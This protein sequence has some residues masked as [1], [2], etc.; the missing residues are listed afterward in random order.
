VLLWSLLVFFPVL[1]CPFG[2]DPIIALEQVWVDCVC[3]L[4]ARLIVMEKQGQQIFLETVRV[5]SRIHGHFSMTKIRA[6]SLGL[7][8]LR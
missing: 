7:G 6:S 1:N 5:G 4:L 3:D 8:L 2:K